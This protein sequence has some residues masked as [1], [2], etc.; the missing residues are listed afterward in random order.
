MIDFIALRLGDLPNTPRDH[1]KALHDGL[2]TQNKITF[3]EPS[4]LLTEQ[5]VNL[6]LVKSYQVKFHIYS[7]L[8]LQF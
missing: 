4:K 3:Y 1:P 2:T 7:W 8:V 6:S 5:G